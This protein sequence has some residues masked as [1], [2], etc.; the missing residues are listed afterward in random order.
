MRPSVE[1]LPEPDLSIHAIGLGKDAPGLD[2]RRKNQVALLERYGLTPRS[3]VLEIG[4]GVGW[5]AYDLAGILEDDGCYTGF[6]VSPAAIGWLNENLAPR[7]PNFRFDLVD[8][9]NPRYRPDAGPP[10]DQVSFPYADREFDLVCAYGVFMH[11]ERNGIARYLRE[12]ARVLEPG[13]PG[14]LSFM[15]MTPLDVDPR[16]GDR[17]YVGVEPGVYSLATRPGGLVVGVRRR[18]DPPP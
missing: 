6:D 14:L 18:V 5:L 17:S 16:N 1:G 13:R 3:R 10:A 11:I 4:C 12:I 2:G 9:R 8:A 15:A 7:L